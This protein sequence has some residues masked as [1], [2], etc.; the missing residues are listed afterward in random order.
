MIYTATNVMP[1]GNLARQENGKITFRSNVHCAGANISVIK[2][3]LINVLNNEIRQTEYY[4]TPTKRVT[5]SNGV[6]KPLVENEDDILKETVLVDS[7]SAGMSIYNRRNGSDLNMSCNLLDNSKQNTEWQYQCTYYQ[8][9]LNPAASSLMY[10][11]SSDMAKKMLEPVYDIFLCSGKTISASNTSSFKI[12]KGIRYL[13]NMRLEQSYRT[14]GTSWSVVVGGAIIKFYDDDNNCV[15]QKEIRSYDSET[16]QI[17]T[18]SG[19][20]GSLGIIPNTKYEIYTNYFVDKPYIFTVSPY[21]QSSVTRDITID[22]LSSDEDNIIDCP[23]LSCQGTFEPN[24]NDLTVLKKYQYILKRKNEVISKSDILYDDRLRYDFLCPFCT[25]E[26]A[27][28]PINVELDITTQANETFTK[29]VNL[30][31]HPTLSNNNF[32]VAENLENAKECGEI[33][34]LFDIEKI[35]EKGNILKLSWKLYNAK[36]G[37]NNGFTVFKLDN[38][39]TYKYIGVQGKK[40]TG[41]EIENGLLFECYDYTYTASQNCIYRIIWNFGYYHDIQISD[42]GKLSDTWTICDLHYQ[43]DQT[44]LG[45]I[46]GAVNIS[47]PLYATNERWTFECNVSDKDI[48]SILGINVNNSSA[49]KPIITRDDKKY[50]QSSFTALLGTIDCQ[51]DKY[52]DNYDRLKK[53]KEFI[54]QDCMFL[55]KSNKGDVWIVCVSDNPTRIY[56]SSVAGVP[57]TV[58][59]AWVEVEDI[60]NIVIN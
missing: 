17:R 38:N 39:G 24:S 28:N 50:E 1:N 52:I 13:E 16:G 51:T 60:D 20:E 54:S 40:P 18:Y 31:S 29:D 5:D 53:W 59:Y 3:E 56:D 21:S 35:V 25:Q 22:S 2:L 7:Y 30:N 12:E 46:Q 9:K 4:P 11:T 26:L 15:A 8:C 32:T 36:Q 14:S 10:T 45:A 33:P 57:T 47:K 43:K 6:S 19:E 37:L 42:V 55:L 34:C 44:T 49:S 58:T 23:M 41:S 48:T 27:T